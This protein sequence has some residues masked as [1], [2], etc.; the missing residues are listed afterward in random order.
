MSA[1]IN[2]TQTYSKRINEKKKL[3]FI[4]LNFLFEIKKKKIESV[5]YID[6]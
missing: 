4:W 2:Y 5:S 3:E 6:H 1:K